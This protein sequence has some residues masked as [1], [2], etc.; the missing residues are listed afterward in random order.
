M[1]IHERKNRI[2]AMKAKGNALVQN[3]TWEVVDDTN[4]GTNIV[5]SKCVLKTKYDVDCGVKR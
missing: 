1:T 4:K 5:D 2:D 3:G